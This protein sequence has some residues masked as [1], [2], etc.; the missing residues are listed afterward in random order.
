M[1]WRKRG[2][3]FERRLK[4]YIFFYHYQISYSIFGS[5]NWLF[6]CVKKETDCQKFSIRII[7]TTKC[8]QFFASRK[9]SLVYSSLG[10]LQIAVCMLWSVHARSGLPEFGSQRCSAYVNCG[11]FD[12]K[13][14]AITRIPINER[15]DRWRVS[16]LTTS[17]L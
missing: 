14:K 3:R 12:Y 6:S 16:L 17:E 11:N 10:D 9:F 15:Q 4:L 1:I 13:Y 2:G 5:T 8:R 7:Q